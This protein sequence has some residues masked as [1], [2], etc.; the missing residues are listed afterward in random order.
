MKIEILSTQSI[1]PSSPT[2]QHLRDFK[3]SFIDERIPSYYTPL[4]LYYASND[5][6]GVYCRLRSSLSEALA[7]FYPLAGRMKGQIL[8]DC[9]DE[10]AVYVEARG[11]GDVLDIVRSPHPQVLEKLIPFVIDGY[12]PR[13]RELLGV[14]VSRAMQIFSCS[15]L[16]FVRN[17]FLDCI[18][19]Q[20]H[21]L[22]SFIEHQVS[23]TFIFLNINFNGDDHF[24]EKEKTETYLPRMKFTP[25]LIFLK[26]LN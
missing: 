17:S 8:V 26:N 5:R 18:L 12:V 16:E 10:G 25:A 1:K 23:P 14:Q 7:K 3:L 11:D 4:I 20:L 22:H 19:M 6:S 9:N 13:A 2:P 24:L 21:F 15:L